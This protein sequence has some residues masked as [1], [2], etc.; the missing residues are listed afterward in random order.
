MVKLSTASTPIRPVFDG[1]AKPREKFSLNDCLD[2]G[3]NLLE[4]IPPILT[5]FRL[6]KVGITADIRKA[7]QQISVIPS[8]R[9]YLRFLW[10][11]DLSAKEVK[12]YRHCRVV[13]GV[14]S[15]PF[16]LGAA[17]HHHLKKAPAQD[18]AAA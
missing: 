4:L 16:L 7:F 12:V 15:S 1:S 10:W 8:D 2:K 6:K 5:R 17:L 14:T 9:D 13:F 3:P 18:T 11:K